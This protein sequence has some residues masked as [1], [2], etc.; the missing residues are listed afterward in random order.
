MEISCHS[1]NLIAAQVAYNKHVLHIETSVISQRV[2]SLI[3]YQHE[4]TL[5]TV[6]NI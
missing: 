4:F 6:Y 3:Y 2:Q 1:Y 5:D